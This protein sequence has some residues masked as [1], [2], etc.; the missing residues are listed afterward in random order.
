MCQAKHESLI[1]SCVIFP[2][3]FVLRNTQKSENR[4]SMPVRWARLKQKFCSFRFF[5]LAI[6]SEAQILTP[7]KAAL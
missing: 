7:K 2:D 4:E 6:I 5:S 1:R 3:L